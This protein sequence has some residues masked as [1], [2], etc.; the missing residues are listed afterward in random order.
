MQSIRF[1]SS[2]VRKKIPD[3]L[4][5][6]RLPKS[7]TYAVRMIESS[8]TCGE[9]NHTLKIFSSVRAP[10]WGCW[11]RCRWYFRIFF[12]LDLFIVGVAVFVRCLL[13]GLAKERY[14]E[15]VIGDG[16]AISSGL[17]RSPTEI[18]SS[19]VFVIRQEAMRLISC[20]LCVVFCNDSK[21]KI[22]EG[23]RFGGLPLLCWRSYR[24]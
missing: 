16:T 18:R 20:R 1:P 5:T 12:L 13:D 23:N 9:P 3:K 15:V 17:M 10:G 24:I 11:M 8:G 14:R 4:V 6:A 7:L 22:G 2:L 21:K 19:M